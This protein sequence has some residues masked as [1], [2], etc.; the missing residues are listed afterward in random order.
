VVA[1][2][3]VVVLVA[4]VVV[5]WRLARRY[6]A[7]SCTPAWLETFS[8]DRYAPMERLLDPS[9]LQ[10]LA[11]QPGYRPEIGKRLL[12]E[13]RQIFTSYLGRLV[14]DF[15]QVV[16]VGKWMIVSSATDRPGFGAALWQQQAAFYW[17]VCLIRC[18]VAVYPW[19]WTAVDVPGLLCTLERLHEEIRQSLRGGLSEPSA[20]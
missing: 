15:N 18:K 1:A 12:K 2:A 9:D 5:L 19:G 13:R 4:L 7:A 3:V 8:M 11:S 16:A 20:S 14:R 6:D 17:S 10:F